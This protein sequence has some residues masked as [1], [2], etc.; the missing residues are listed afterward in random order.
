MAEAL[1]GKLFGETPRL[2]YGTTIRVIKPW[3]R[4]RIRDCWHG[5]GVA[6]RGRAGGL[7]IRKVP[8]KGRVH[9]GSRAIG[10]LSGTAAAADCGAWLH[11]DG[12]GGTVF[13]GRRKSSGFRRVYPCQ[14]PEAS[15]HCD[16]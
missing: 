7:E 11:A 4:F 8:Q 16:G 1:A 2:S 13:A 6:D 9:S 5:A 3:N 14:D 15:E 10:W 12:R